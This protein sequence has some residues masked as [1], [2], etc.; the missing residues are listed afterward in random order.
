MEEVGRESHNVRMRHGDDDETNKAQTWATVW[1]IMY[2]RSLCIR[3][4]DS[5]V[6]N[7]PTDSLFTCM[8]IPCSFCRFSHCENGSFELLSLNHP[9]VTVDRRQLWTIHLQQNREQKINSWK[10]FVWGF[11]RTPN[12]TGFP[13]VSY[14]FACVRFHR[15]SLNS[16][17]DHQDPLHCHQLED[18][19]DDDCRS[20]HFQ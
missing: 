9:S 3:V 2:A 10:P 7:V 14:I 11:T 20:W 18:E 4:T 6:V 17:E 12:T 5:I 8:W 1:S 16:Y 13:D 19:L 15:L